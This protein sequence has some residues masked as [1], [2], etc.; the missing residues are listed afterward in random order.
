VEEQR[1]DYFFCITID[2]EDLPW[3]TTQTVWW[4][5]AIKFWLLSVLTVWFFRVRSLVTLFSQKPEH[6]W[7]QHIKALEPNFFSPTATCRQAITSLLLSIQHS[8]NHKVQFPF[9]ID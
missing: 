1:K 4:R 8:T 3:D 6:A 9:P 5:Y 7:K 2:D